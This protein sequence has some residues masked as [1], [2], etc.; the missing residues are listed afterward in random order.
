[1]RHLAAEG[2]LEGILNGI[3]EEEFD[4]SRDPFLE[5][6][7]SADDLSGKAKSK[8]ALLKELGLPEIADT[9][10]CGL[11]TRLSEQKGIDLIVESASRLLGEVQI[12]VLG[13]GDPRIAEALH[14]LRVKYPDRIAFHDGFNLGL[15]P[16]IYAGSDLFMMP[17]SFEPCGLGQLIAMRYGTI[18]I[19]RKTGGLADTVQ[20]G[21]NGFVF[22]DRSS[23][24]LIEAALRAKSAYL[25][26]EWTEMVKRVMGIDHAWGKS[27]L[28]YVSLYERALNR[29]RGAR[30]KRREA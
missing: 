3:D 28:E 29:R 18:P 8:A 9:P 30:P 14:Y 22:E 20:D 12:I 25:D 19:V 1:M 26:K 11:V 15:A 17:S 23:F 13:N 6:R 4:P 2:R 21:E 24:A 5:H 27:A 10:L 7:Y 16:R